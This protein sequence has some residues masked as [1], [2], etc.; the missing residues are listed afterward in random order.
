MSWNCQA[1]SHCL[2]SGDPD[3]VSI[4]FAAAMTLTL[5]IGH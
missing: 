2:V 3:K 5:L 1:I 4:I